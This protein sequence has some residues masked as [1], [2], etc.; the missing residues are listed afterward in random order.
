[1][2]LFLSHRSDTNYVTPKGETALTTAVKRNHIHLIEPLINAGA[3]AAHVS[4]LGF[5]AI[6]YAILGGFYEIAKLLYR[7]LPNKEK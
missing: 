5:S 2:T 6:D 4:K 7:R 1:V 3:D